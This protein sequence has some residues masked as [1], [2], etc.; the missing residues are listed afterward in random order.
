MH[1]MKDHICCA[2][3]L[4]LDTPPAHENIIDEIM[5]KVTKKPPTILHKH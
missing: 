4:S 1:H 5:Q 2:E 3:F